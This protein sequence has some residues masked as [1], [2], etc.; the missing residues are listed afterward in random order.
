M[1]TKVIKVKG[2][3]FWAKVFEENRDME[4]W[5]GTAKEWN[6]QYLINVALDSDSVMELTAAGSQAVD[7]PKELT[8]DNGNSYTCYK[9]K[10]RH[11]HRNR[12]GELMEWASGAPKVLKEDGSPWD[13]ENDGTIG[14]LSTV[15]LTVAVYDA[16]RNKGTRLESVR[17]LDYVA[18]PVKAVA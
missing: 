17:V 3:A 13:I 18:P 5:D 6:G 15:E 2:K 11:E 10:R 7:Y 4:G 14:N 1:A 8:D 16:G 9:F 12:K